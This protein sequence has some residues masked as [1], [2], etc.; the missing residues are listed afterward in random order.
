M[1]PPPADRLLQATAL[2]ASFSRFAQNNRHAEGPKKSVADKENN[3]SIYPTA[4]LVS[5]R[6]VTHNGTYQG[7]VHWRCAT[8]TD[9]NKPWI[10]A[11]STCPWLGEQRW[12]GGCQCQGE[13][14]GR[15]MEGARPA[16]ASFL[17]LYTESAPLE[18][19]RSMHWDPETD[20][21]RK[22]LTR[23]DLQKQISNDWTNCTHGSR[24]DHIMHGS[25]E[26]ERTPG[27]VAFI[28][29]IK[30]KKCQK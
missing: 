29:C 27:L 14:H 10:L 16:G 2:T 1:L 20:K 4:I 11:F 21:R 18:P 13:S 28:S 19:Y 22:S 3:R 26:G 30:W 9:R 23:L 7:Q 15:P 24:G 6:G 8:K 12:A 5:S 17:L 25:I